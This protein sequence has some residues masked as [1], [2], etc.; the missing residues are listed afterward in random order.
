MDSFL[1]LRVRCA[2]TASNQC[3]ARVFSSLYPWWAHVNLAK[4]TL[5]VQILQSLT[6]P[7]SPPVYFS[8][9]TK[10]LRRCLYSWR[11]PGNW[12]GFDEFSSAACAVYLCNTSRL[13]DLTWLT[14]WL[15]NWLTDATN[16]HQKRE[17]SIL[18]TSSTKNYASIAIIVFEI[19]QVPQP[20]NKTNIQRCN[21]SRRWL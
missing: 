16:V 21:A 9:I 20:Y 4:Y 7:R 10:F 14:D 13:L 18:L 15:T 17:Q 1:L 2:V 6:S 5:T 19:V 8:V 3:D 12:V 11:D